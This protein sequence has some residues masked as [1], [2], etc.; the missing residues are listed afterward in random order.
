MKLQEGA[1]E[2]IIT[3]EL[4]QDMKQ[5]ESDGLVCKQE[6]M[7]T[8]ETHSM[9]AEHVNK[10][11]LNKLSDDNLTAEERTDF[12]NKLIDFISPISTIDKIVPAITVLYTMPDYDGYYG[13]SSYH[14]C[15]YVSFFVWCIGLFHILLSLLCLLIFA[16]FHGILCISQ[17]IFPVRGTL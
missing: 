17:I 3:S 8:S 13:K 1:Y 6:D 11:V 14:I 12:V 4:Q 9:L 5:A 10:L 2:N 15:F 16:D 7:D